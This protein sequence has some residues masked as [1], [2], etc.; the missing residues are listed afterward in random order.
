ML[1]W[2]SCVFCQY[3]ANQSFRK[4]PKLYVISDTFET[5]GLPKYIHTYIHTYINCVEWDVNLFCKL[6]VG[7]K[8]YKSYK[9]DSGAEKTP[10][11]LTVKCLLE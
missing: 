8:T 9:K 1:S 7:G 3:V 4:S 10:K 11:M 2:L 5:I 6:A